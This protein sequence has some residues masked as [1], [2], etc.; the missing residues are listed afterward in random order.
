MVMLW[1]DNVSMY[2]WSAH[3]PCPCLKM[4]LVPI[5]NQRT[6]WYDV[7]TCSH[8]G[9]S[10]FGRVCFGVEGDEERS[11]VN[12]WSH[13]NISGTC[14]QTQCVDEHAVVLCHRLISDT[15]TEMVKKE[16]E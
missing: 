13:V 14:Q 8:F 2:G 5:L 16:A 11:R 7:L 15:V 4:I 10:H 9:R 12:P 3:Q 6:L 1:L